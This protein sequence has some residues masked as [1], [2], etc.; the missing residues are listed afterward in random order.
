MKILGMEEVD[1]GTELIVARGWGLRDAATNPCAQCPSKCCT[2]QIALTTV[3][4]MRMAFTLRLPFD[5][6]LE[7]APMSYSGAERFAHAIDLDT[8]P[9]KLVLKRTDGWCTH[10][11]RAGTEHSRCGVYELRPAVCRLF[12]FLFELDGEE[13]SVG[14]GNPICPHRWAVTPSTAE[15]LQTDALQWKEDVTKDAEIVARFNAATRTDRSLTGFLAWLR[16]DAGPA[17]GHNPRAFDRFPDRPKFAFLKA[18][19]RRVI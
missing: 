1:D 10:L 4:A 17:L 15:R 2:F 7:A 16:D 6:F 19:T 8:G 5:A 11:L 9:S 14:S 13:T 18:T 3:E 12:P